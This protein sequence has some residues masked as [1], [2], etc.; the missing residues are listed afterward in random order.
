MLFRSIVVLDALPLTPNGKID[1][2]A[3]P[4]PGR[5]DGPTRER[6]PPRT[7][8]EKRVAAA[9]AVVLGLDEVGVEDDFFELGGHSL[10]A[11]RVIFRL[12]EQLDLE[13]PLHSLFEAPT[14]EGLAGRIDALTAPAA[15]ATSTLELLE[16]LSESEAEK[17]LAE[18]A[19]EGEV[20]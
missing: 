13:L 10:L 5:E 18:L 3:L 17:L 19:A 20:G 2:R 12:R 8:V 16:G 7:A 14:V 9:F 6:V 1:R 11:T 15:I 4:A